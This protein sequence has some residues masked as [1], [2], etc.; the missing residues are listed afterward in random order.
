M[1]NHIDR[2]ARINLLAHRGADEIRKD[3]A[4]AFAEVEREARERPN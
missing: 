2:A 1:L 4:Q 3:I